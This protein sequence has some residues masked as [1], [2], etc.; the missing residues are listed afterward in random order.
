MFVNIDAE[1]IRNCMSRADLA[2][3]L[4]V[5]PDVLNDWIHRR[6]AIPAEKLRVLAA[7]FSDVT[8]DFLLYRKS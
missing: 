1:R 3:S 6:R 7:V 2:R 8:L 4:A 5:C